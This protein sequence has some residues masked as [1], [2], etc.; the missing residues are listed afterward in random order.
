MTPRLPWHGIHTVLLDMDGTLLDLH[1]DNYFFQET[2]PRAYAEKN[3]LDL[4]TARIQVFDAYQDNRGTL[5]WYDLDHWSRQLGL[6]IAI[7][8]EEVAHLIRVHPHVL[9]FLAAL[10][11]SGR[12]AHLV[13]NAHAIS[14]NMKLARTPIGDYLT[15]IITS[16][17]VGK[18]KEEA[19]F[20]PLLMERLGFDP[21]TTL[22]VDDS[23]PVL[24]AAQAFGIAHL[25]HIANPSSGLPPR[26]SARFLSVVDFRELAL[27]DP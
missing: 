2:V 24:A 21:A 8:K 18:A 14:L 11:A 4:A 10:R 19:A 25:R 1:F 9:P 6:E 7:L 16:H 26:P 23:E 15:S 13:T 12:P 27:P 5:A 20:W 3:G 17:E 22:L